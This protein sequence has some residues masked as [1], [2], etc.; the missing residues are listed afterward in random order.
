MLLGAS[1]LGVYTLTQLPGGGGS[2]TLEIAK[3][4]LTL[5]GS[6][7]A[8]TQAVV[9][10]KGDLTLTGNNI[11]FAP[12]LAIITG[13]LTLVGQSAAFLVTETITKE[14][15]TL[16]GGSIDLNVTEPVAQGI[17]T[18]TGYATSFAFTFGI[19]PGNLTLTGQ[20]ATL[21][22]IIKT[23]KGDLHLTPNDAGLIIIGGGNGS[24]A[25]DGDRPR[26][27]RKTGFEP[28]AKRPDRKIIIKR[29]DFLPPDDLIGDSV[30]LVPA[31][32][33]PQP[34]FA[35]PGSIMAMRADI[36]TAQDLADINRLLYGMAMD[37]QDMADILDVLQLID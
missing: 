25:G 26:R 29:D 1:P 6:S 31:G 13:A 28:I 12:V 8:L 30:P 18:L 16:A 3:G 2:A 10:A 22:Q 17:L 37:H 15:L 34:D 32:P 11:A 4:D 19:Q 23:T 9:A 20:H 24:S 5:A 33:P 35:E 21:T 27:K 7:I 14:N 36:I